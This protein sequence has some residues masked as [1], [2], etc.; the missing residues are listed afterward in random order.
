MLPV[1]SSMVTGLQCL[2]RWLFPRLSF[3]QVPPNLGETQNASKQEFQFDYLCHG[4][5]D[6]FHPAH[7]AQSM[8][9]VDCRCDR[10]WNYLGR[11]AQ[12]EIV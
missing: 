2:T 12:G 7:A 8:V 3:R 1:S 11:E 5:L 4:G 9:S 10:I 6:L